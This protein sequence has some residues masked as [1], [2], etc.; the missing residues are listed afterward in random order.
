MKVICR[1]IETGLMPVLFYLSSGDKTSDVSHT[2]TVE[3]IN[4]DICTR[5][6][7][8]QRMLNQLGE[9]TKYLLAKST[10][11]CNLFCLLG[12]TSWPNYDATRKR[13]GIDLSTSQVRTFQRPENCS[14]S[15]MQTKLLLIL[16]LQSILPIFSFFTLLIFVVKLECL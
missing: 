14:H 3:Q 15:G 10:I 1:C 12:E 16:K 4:D 6:Y 13:F 8:V 7:S 5:E 2:I 11:L 9:H